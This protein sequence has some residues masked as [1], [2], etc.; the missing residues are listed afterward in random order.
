MSKH[1]IYFQPNDRDIFDSYADC[2][3]R[4]ICAVTG[5]SYETVAKGI[6]A[7]AIK[8]KMVADTYMAVGKYLESIG[9]E[10]YVVF[11]KDSGY[12]VKRFLKQLRFKE[13]VSDKSIRKKLKNT[14]IVFL[15]SN[16]A[17][18]SVHGNYY[19]TWDSGD[20]IVEEI[21]VKF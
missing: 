2:S 16:H 18:G 5:K 20:T 6:N 15:G 7:I 13:K 14:K 21:Y 1:F 19:D 4:A 11:S 9:F 17:V 8:Y 3:I 12:T 10:R